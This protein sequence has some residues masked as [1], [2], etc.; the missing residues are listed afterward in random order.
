MRNMVDIILSVG[1]TF[2]S[3]GN[4]EPTVKVANIAPEGV[5]FSRINNI[6]FSF[7]MSWKN[8]LL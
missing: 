3:S 5:C 2:R 4:R 8:Y 6:G 1:T 7:E